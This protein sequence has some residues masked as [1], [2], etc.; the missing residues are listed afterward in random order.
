MRK[1]IFGFLLS[2]IPVFCLAQNAPSQPF[3]FNGVTGI[4]VMPSGTLGI[5]TT[6]PNTNSVFDLSG[7]TSA[8]IL[9][10]GTTSNRPTGAAGMMRWNTA[11]PGVEVYTGSAWSQLASGGSVTWPASGDLVISNSTSSPNGLAPVNGQYACG[12]GGVW[13]TCSGTSGS[14][15]LG[16]SGS[17]TSPQ[18]SGDSTSGF[19]TAGA[20]LVDVSIS[21][22]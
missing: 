2:I 12:A 7:N 16:S 22:A 8:M 9:P 15:T 6:S 14:S 10:I 4:A 11:L 13:T 20:G 17:S 21:S 5:G 1:L 19:Y 3:N 18:I